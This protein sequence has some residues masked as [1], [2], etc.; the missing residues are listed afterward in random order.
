MMQYY[1]YSCHDVMCV[2][3]CVMMQYYVYS[4]VMMRCVSDCVIMLYY[5]HSCVM[6]QCVSVTVSC[7]M[8]CV[9]VYSC[10]NGGICLLYTSDAAD[11]S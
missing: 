5:V 4:C 9:C 8:Q 1:V 6:M 7:M 3:D 2:Y 11:E 10:D